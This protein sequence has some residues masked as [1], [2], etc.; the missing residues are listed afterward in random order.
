MVIARVVSGAQ[1]GADQIALEVAAELGLP[2]GG[3]IGKG[4]ITEDGPR[5][6]LIGRYGLAELAT[7][8]YPARTRMNVF[9]SDATLLVCHDSGSPGT[10]LVRRLARECD[11]RPL[12]VVDLNRD[13]NPL[14]TVE[15]LRELAE[16]VYGQALTLNIAGNRASGAPD[17]FEDVCRAYLMM[18][19]VLALREERCASGAGEGR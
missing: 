9:G 4:A 6:E 5:P 15:W 7:A 3:W 12:R 8:E 2:T 17:W 11:D 18:T 10:K 13:R 14:P 1:S 19:F 16:V